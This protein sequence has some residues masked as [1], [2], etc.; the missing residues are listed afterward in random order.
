MA[1]RAS[2]RQS[3][4]AVM[5]QQWPNTLQGMASLWQWTWSAQVCR[6][7]AALTWLSRGA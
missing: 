7:C 2:T 4:C 3:L 1:R 6:R 5:A